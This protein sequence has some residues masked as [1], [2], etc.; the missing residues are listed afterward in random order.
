M[1]DHTDQTED[2]KRPLFTNSLFLLF[3]S[4]V[5]FIIVGTIFY[6]SAEGW[7]WID[8]FYFSV[9]TLTTV[10]Y[11]DLV[12][13]SDASKLFTTGYVLSGLGLMLTFVQAVARKQVEDSFIRKVLNA[14]RPKDSDHK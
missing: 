8:S 11:G 13:S 4:V 12:P 2:S 3:I 14:R 6:H 10:G 7:D 9:M 1:N 5:S